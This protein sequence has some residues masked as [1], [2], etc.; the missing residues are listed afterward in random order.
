MANRYFITSEATY[1]IMRQALNAELGY[2]N[3]LGTSIIHTPLQAPRD[4]YRRVLLR[5]DTDLPG[6]SA[7]N[8]AVTPLLNGDSMEEISEATYIAAVNS[9]AGTRAWSTITGTPTTLAGYGITNAPTLGQFQDLQTDLQIYTESLSM[10]AFTGSASD[11]EAGTVPFDRLP[12]GQTSTTVAVGNDSRFTN[13]RTPTGAA[14]GDLTGTYP[15]P[16]IAPGAVVTADLADSAVTTAKIADSA[17]TD[18]KVSAV[19]ASKLTGTVA[20]ARLT[21]RQRASTNLYLWSSFR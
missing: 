5:V 7:I 15:N 18:A 16:T 11:L 20:N 1:E 2:P 21:T 14:G 3:N 4:A 12:V 13:A 8:A 19:A 6:Y 17:V 9:A 10:V